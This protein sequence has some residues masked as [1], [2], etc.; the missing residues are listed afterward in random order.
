MSITLLKNPKA[1]HTAL[2]DG[3]SAFYVLLWIAIRYLRHNLNQ[4]DIRERLTMFDEHMINIVSYQYVGGRQ[5]EYQVPQLRQP[6][7]GIQFK[8]N[9]SEVTDLIRELAHV[10]TE[11]YTV[12]D[13]LIFPPGAFEIMKEKKDRNMALLRSETWLIEKLRAVDEKLKTRPDSNDSNEDE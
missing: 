5:K 9:I 4:A 2:D 11:R 13:P 3:E 8:D 6:M 10:F 12:V 1:E 7:T